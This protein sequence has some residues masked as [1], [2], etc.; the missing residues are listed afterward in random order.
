MD[1]DQSA[2]KGMQIECEA[3]CVSDL[4][5]HDGMCGLNLHVMDDFQEFVEQRVSTAMFDKLQSIHLLKEHG[6]GQ[7]NIKSI[8]RDCVGSAFEEYKNPVEPQLEQMTELHE[9]P[10]R[11]FE[12]QDESKSHPWNPI[13]YEVNTARRLNT[14]P[15]MFLDS[16]LSHSDSTILT[17]SSKCTEDSVS[18]DWL[19][20]D[21]ESLMP[22]SSDHK[23]MMKL[24]GST[25]GLYSLEPR[26]LPS[27]TSTQPWNCQLWT[28]GPEFCGLEPLHE[29]WEAADGD[30]IDYGFENISAG[31]FQAYT[32]LE[33]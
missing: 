10:E 23:D 14:S 29:S 15:N 20:D 9:E 16:A 13:G 25:E 27:V 3:D 19:S 7:E 5:G 12:P 32:C 8:I 6:E 17:L 22:D 21:R 30:S 11:M 24:F 31:T 4:D 28:A 2:Y 26:I 1:L 18:F 33:H